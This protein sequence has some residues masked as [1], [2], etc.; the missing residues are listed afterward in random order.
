MPGNSGGNNWSPIS[1]DRKRKLAFVGAMALPVRYQI[2]KEVDEGLRDLAAGGIRLGGN[3][4]FEMEGAAGFFS[5]IDLTTGKIKWQR[6]SP[7]PYIGGVL[8]TSTGIAFQGEPGGNLTA[9]DA[10]SGE[11][12][13]QFNTGAGVTAPPI[14]FELDGE[15][16]I[17]VAAGGS[18]LWSTPLGDSVFVFGLPK[19]W[20]PAA[21]K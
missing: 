11:V 7:M 8:S 21:K 18:A 14:A 20:E 5:A 3:W 19:R 2:E 17:A 1:V 4:K 12:L 9:L 16:F 13:W 10:E 15:E 6:K